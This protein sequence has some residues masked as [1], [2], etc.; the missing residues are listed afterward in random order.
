MRRVFPICLAL[1]VFLAVTGLQ[2][3]ARA[4]L[5]GDTIGYPRIGFNSEG[6]IRY[7]ADTLTLD[8]AAVPFLFEFDETGPPVFVTGDPS[9]GLVSGFTVNIQVDRSGVLVGSAGADDLTLEGKIDLTPFGY[10]VYS[11]TLLTGEAL[12][13]GYEDS[14]LPAEADTFDFRFLP[15]GGQ[16]APL[17]Y[18]GRY[19]GVE[20]F[21][22]SCTFMGDF[23]TSFTGAA[24][25]NIGPTPIPEPASMTL[26]GIG[27]AG[28]AAARR[29]R[30]QG[31]G[32]CRSFQPM[33][34]A[35]VRDR[36]AHPEVGPSPVTGPCSYLLARSRL[37]VTWAGVS[38]FPSYDPKTGWG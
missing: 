13:F 9:T 5:I 4:V 33:H 11:G 3:P 26:L 37:P 34:Q 14:E 36:S 28:L 38:R 35:V 18:G 23:S 24:A 19:I 30:R 8:I 17:F 32:T 29:T 12:L 25:G 10:G 2:D 21:S 1:T 6:Q 31:L 20:L 16:I 22:Q 27:L 15:T 7:T